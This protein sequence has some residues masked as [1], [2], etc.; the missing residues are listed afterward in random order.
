MSVSSKTLLNH[1]VIRR[2]L[3]RTAVAAGLILAATC[4][5][6]P[7]QA[8][9]DEPYTPHYDL[10]GNGVVDGGDAITAAIGWSDLAQDSLC[11]PGSLVSL[12]V[13]GDGCVDVADVQLFAAQVGTMQMAP[14]SAAPAAEPELATW[15]VTVAT[16]EPDAAPGDGKC[17]SALGTCT[18]RAAI[19]E[20]NLHV[21]PDLITFN[22]LTSQGACPNVASI[23]VDPLAVTAYTL[24]DPGGYGTTIDGYT[25]CGASPN[26]ADTHGNAVIKVELRGKATLNLHGIRLI[27]PNNVIRGLAIYN[28]DRQIELYGRRAR[29]NRIEG[30]IIGTNVTQRFQAANLG[31]HHSEGI[32]VQLG[33]SYNVIGCGSFDG[34]NTFVPCTDQAAINAA[35]NIIAGNGNDGLHFEREATYNHVV[36]NYIGLKQDGQTSLRNKTDCIDVEQGPK[37]N[38]IGG[39]TPAERN[40]VGGCGSDGIEISH[41][42]ETQFNHVAGNYFGLDA[43]GTKS[44]D[45]V[46]NGIS[47]EDTVDSNYAHGNYVSGTR[48]NGVRFYVLATRN[49]VYDNIIG[50][51]VDGKPL[52]N[53]DSS[54]VYIMG[55]SSHNRIRNNVIANHPN[56]GI[57]LHNFSDADHDGFGTTFY[58]TI[59]RNSIYNNGLE[60]IQFSPKRKVYPNEGLPAPRMSVANTIRVAGTACANCTV[61]IFIADKAT[62]NPQDVDQSGE[63][64]TFVG[65]GTADS[66][67]NFMIAISEV[68]EGTVLTATAT[69]GKGNTSMFGQN[70]AVAKILVGEPTPTPVPPTPTPTNQPAQPTA[71]P[72]PPGRAPDQ[73]YVWIPLVVR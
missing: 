15:R 66:F 12:D 53:Q 17:R 34:A 62:V 50:L 16:D 35:R 1:I 29:Y 32:R 37:Y 7:L 64:K 63:G 13:Q 58:N 19:Q 41:N 22:I 6:T 28:F 44:T 27:S 57:W 55:G 54:G 59:S 21:G 24:D 8:Q 14:R 71:T 47:F 51:S 26:T 4:L 49:E 52:P 46:G 56:A 25:Q 11:A 39:M 61:E 33:P 20:A 23:N 70:I 9:L 48:S 10:T 65:A 30:T 73:S 69:D 2:W 31:T 40:V 67:G 18:L 5:P 36:G 60:G 3:R 72:T 45:V 43:T 68:P 42:T 38:W